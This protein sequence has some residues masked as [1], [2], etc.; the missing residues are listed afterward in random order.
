MYSTRIIYKRS[1]IGYFIGQLGQQFRKQQCR[2]QPYRARKAADFDCDYDI[3][4]IQ[5]QGGGRRDP[6]GAGS[7]HME[8]L[9]DRD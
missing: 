8:G 4:G 2:K 9:F 7:R 1:L 5:S 6:N 3:S